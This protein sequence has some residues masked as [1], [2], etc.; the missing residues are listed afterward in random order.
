[1][2]MNLGYQTGSPIGGFTKGLQAGV[3]LRQQRQQ[4]QRAEEQLGMQRERLEMDA[5]QAERMKV[6][7]E[8]A[9]KDM[10]R[11]RGYN[12]ILQD[13]DSTAEDKIRALYNSSIEEGDAKAKD[14]VLKMAIAFRQQPGNADKFH[15][16]LPMINS[17]L[18]EDAKENEVVINRKDGSIVIIDKA[19]GTSREILP[20]TKELGQNGRTSVEMQDFKVR[21]PFVDISTPSGRELYM[22]DQTMMQEMR[23]FNS[24]IDNEMSSPTAI[25]DAKMNK[26]ILKKRLI[27][28]AT[29]A[30]E[31]SK[32]TGNGGST[33][34]PSGKP[35][36][37]ASFLK[38]AQTR[39]K[40]MGTGDPKRIV[41][42]FNKIMNASPY[43]PDV[44]AEPPIDMNIQP[45]SAISEEFQ[46]DPQAI[47]ESE[48]REVTERNRKSYGTP[49]F[50]Q[51]TYGGPLA[52]GGRGRSY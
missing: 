29:K 12:A 16:L 34:A 21:Y 37:P 46:M 30:Y 42:E 5:A 39:A 19:L 47:L 27:E 48:R 44:I 20:A 31:Q 8:Q 23:R 1:M 25:E 2:A 26:E 36:M 41:E 13:P 50:N 9:A 43:D 14:E 15:D 38:D 22:E 40:V 10:E 6:K 17:R 32:G 3:G 45:Q 33:K 35:P 18:A 28:G 24:I 4:G 49:G 51:G 11:K 7:D 52:T